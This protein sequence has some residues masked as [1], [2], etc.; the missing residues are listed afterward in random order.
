MATIS[1]LTTLFPPLA[2]TFWRAGD[3]GLHWRNGALQDSFWKA[4]DQETLIVDGPHIRLDSGLY[5]VDFQLSPD[6]DV[7]DPSVLVATVQATCGG[8]HVLAEMPVSAGQLLEGAE[9]LYQGVRLDMVVERPVEDME[10]RVLSAG[11]SAFRLHGIKL[12]PRPGRVWFPAAL[13]YDA[14]AWEVRADRSASCQR[15]A[16]LGGPGIELAPGDYRLGFKLKPPPEV[17]SGVVAHLKV[18]GVPLS[19]EEAVGEPQAVVSDR[20]VSTEELLAHRGIPDAKLRFR[21]EQPYRR[22]EFRVKSLMAGVVVQ[23]VRLAT[24]DEAVWHHYYHLGGSAS[25]LGTPT[26]GFV[27][28]GRS[29]NGTL[30]FYRRFQQGITY[31]TVENGPCEIY[32]AIGD[33]YQNAGGPCGELG[34]PTSRPQP[35]DTSSAA[36]VQRFEGGT[37]TSLTDQQGAIRLERSGTEIAT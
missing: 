23:W 15:P 11:S 26:G 1:S 16:T 3:P 25:I 19:V 31:W 13:S 35:V 32:G 28:A 6:G 22:V 36:L 21:L 7:P 34:F 14:D 10:F 37:L 20:P 9:G 29:V 12:I 30:G 24:A 27:F 5:G 4:G 18:V 33:Y 17:T 2:K 8:G